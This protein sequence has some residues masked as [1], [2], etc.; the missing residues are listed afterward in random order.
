MVRTRLKE[1]KAVGQ[2]PVNDHGL[3]GPPKGFPMKRYALPLLTLAIIGCG[4]EES[5]G[6]STSSVEGSLALSTFPAVPTAVEAK[7]ER[8]STL[9]ANPGTDGAFRLALP[10]AHTYALAIVLPSGEVPLVFPRST[11]KLDNTFRVNGGAG[12]VLLGTIR[13]LASAP[14]GGF[15]MTSS[16]GDAG[17]GDGEC[18]T[19]VDQETGAPCV[20]DGAQAYCKGDDKQDDGGA[21]GECEN[22]KDATTGAPCQDE[23]DEQDDD[24][25]DGECEN[26]KD[27]TT[28]APCQ[29]EEGAFGAPDP[30][31]P[32]AVP[33]H[34]MPDQ[35]D[36]CD[37]GED[38]EDPND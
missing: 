29:D 10:K 15:V 34:N 31:G 26:G 3:F 20:D 36:G 18:E 6:S 30:S 22:G 14:A 23:N 32:M 1:A 2:E 13:H 16:A 9:R 4:S 38:G 25:A 27:A 19:G 24:G 17:D 35:I 8:G 12:T 21:D 33:E 11:G 5:S 7:D 28:G 37:G